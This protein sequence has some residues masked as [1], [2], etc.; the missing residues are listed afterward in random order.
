TSSGRSILLPAFVLIACGILGAF[1]DWLTLVGRRGEG[2]TVRFKFA[3]LFAIGLVA[4]V[5]L[6]SF[7][8]ID[9]V[10]VPTIK[11]EFH[12]GV[13]FVPLAV[14]AIVSTANA[15]NI[16]DGLDSLAGWTAAI[17]FV[18]YG[19]ISLLY[20]NAFLL[21]FCFIMVGAVLAF[22]WYNAH[23][24]QVFMGDTGSLA[25]GATLAVV[26][27]MLGQVLLLPIIGFLFAAETLSVI[28]QVGYF[29]L[30]RGK[31][32]FRMAPLHHHFELMGWSETHVTQRFWLVSMLASMLGVALA[33]V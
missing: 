33:L 1:D 12:L 26:A 7:L 11:R 14:L 25:I 10:F 6:Y 13:W 17:A 31:R 19:I 30:T 22:L 15:V 2:I 28:L 24:A 20:G 23:P 29:K 5:G 18:A 21:T 4:A 9:F 16:T 27:L 3:W 8:G 32:L